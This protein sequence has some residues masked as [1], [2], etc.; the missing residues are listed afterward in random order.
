MPASFWVNVLGKSALRWVGLSAAGS[1]AGGAI[2]F[3]RKRMLSTPKPA[4]R[5][6]TTISFMSSDSSC[7]QLADATFTVSSRP[8]FAPGSVR[9]AMRSPTMRRHCSRS[10]AVPAKRAAAS[11]ELVKRDPSAAGLSR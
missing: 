1:R 9:A 4:A 5:M 8:R 2:S 6:R 7:A 3:T 11:R 10:I